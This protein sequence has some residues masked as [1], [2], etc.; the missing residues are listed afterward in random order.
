[1]RAAAGLLTV[2]LA[3]LPASAPAQ[4]MGTLDNRQDIAERIQEMESLVGG[5][6]SAQK[7]SVTLRWLAD[8]YVAAGRLDDAEAAYRQILVFFPGDPATSNDYARFLMNQRND[9]ARADSLLH[10]AIAWANARPDPPPYLGQTYALRARA[11]QALGRCDDAMAPTERAIA[12]LDETGVEEALR[13]QAECL[14][15]T[16]RHDA[17]RRAWLD[18]IGMTGGSNPDDT[19]R[20]IALMTAQTGRVSADKVRADIAD[21]IAASRKARR[22]AATAEGAEIV[23]LRGEDGARIESTLRRGASGTAVVFVPEPGQR[24]TAF[25][26][27]AQ[28]MTLDGITTLTV[29]PRGFGD[30]RCDTIPDAFALSDQQR[31]R[32]PGDI[33]AAI[34]YLTERENIPATAIVVV[35]VGEGSQYVERALHEAALPVAAAHLSPV[36]D[37]ENKALAAALSFR[38]QRPVLLIASNEDV[39]AVRSMGY[40]RDVAD[41]AR[42]SSKVFVDAGHGVTLL[43]EPVR[44]LVLS[45]WIAGVF[46]S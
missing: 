35:A 9:P 38:S 1:M 37:T 13:V 17:A 3:L 21:A 25:T 33:T 11:L 29:D 7:Q 42:I 44:Y 26:P 34:R 19:S 14:S 8:L 32:I 10:D 46:G 12:L 39:Y 27:Y 40:F 18:V 5:D 31:D 16:G 30:S 36:F 41:D 15:E 24:R 22:H 20:Y 43:R 23:E 4:G 45:G 6:E 2:A 28:L